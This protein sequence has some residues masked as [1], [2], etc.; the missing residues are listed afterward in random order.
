MAEISQQ[1]FERHVA[2]VGS[3]QAI[4]NLNFAAKLAK[5]K[6]AIT[7]EVGREIL[8]NVE[9]KIE[10]LNFKVIMDDE[11]TI[12]DKMELRAY[13]KIYVDWV[14]RLHK[15]EEVATKIQNS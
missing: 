10:A 9:S 12:A 5:T 1:T 8:K 14:E 13:V 3:R 6:K 2:I 4:K 15:F 11:A 7:T